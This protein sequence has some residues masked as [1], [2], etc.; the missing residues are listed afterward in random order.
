M[1]NLK[2]LLIAFLLF[3]LI[4]VPVLAQ[5]SVILKAD[6]ISNSKTKIVHMN[7]DKIGKFDSVSFSVYAMGEIDIDQLLVQGGLFV[8]ELAYKNATVQNLSLYET[9]ETITLTIDN[10]D[11]TATY[12]QDVGTITKTEARGYNSLK[13]TLTA[14]ASGNDATDATQ[15]FI[16]VATVYK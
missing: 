5:E 8:K 1:V 15:K 12:V 4:S 16:L 10:A 2:K 6:S 14:G 9:V 3:A 7:L 11:G 13:L